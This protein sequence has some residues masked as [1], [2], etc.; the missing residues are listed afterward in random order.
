M[1][2][3]RLWPMTVV[4]GHFGTPVVITRRTWHGH[5][6]EGHPEMKP[7]LD[8]VMATIEEPDV[9]AR[10]TRH[11]GRVYFNKRWADISDFPAAWLQAMVLLPRDG[12]FAR[13]LSAWPAR[14]V[15]GKEIVWTAE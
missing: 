2:D 5:V 13:L 11:P 14:R 9:I 6:V 7:Y 10:D 12:S 8:L 1:E 3:G 15:G 4:A